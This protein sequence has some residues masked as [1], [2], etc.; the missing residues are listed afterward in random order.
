MKVPGSSGWRAPGATWILVGAPGL[1]L[2]ALVFLHEPRPAWGLAAVL[3]TL[4]GSL[5]AWL[6][7]RHLGRAREPRR[8]RD[9]ESGG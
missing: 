4:L 8:G 3:G 6:A 1:V 9:G 5:G 7:W 2:A